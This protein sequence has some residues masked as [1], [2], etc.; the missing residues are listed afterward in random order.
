MRLFLYVA[1]SVFAVLQ[2]EGKTS[3][4]AFPVTNR[5]LKARYSQKVRSMPPMRGVMLPQRDCTEKDFIALR[6]WGVKLCRYQMTRNWGRHNTDRDLAE[7]DS[8]VSGRLDHLEIVLEL[9][10]KHEMKIVVDLHTPPG[11]RRADGVMNMFYEQEYADHFVSLWNTIARRFGNRD[12]IFGFDLINEPCQL[13]NAPFDYWNLQRRAAEEIR[14]I[15]PCTPIIMEAN[16]WD[17]PD[18]YSYMSPIDVYNV[19]YQVHVYCPGEFT[20]QGTSGKFRCLPNEW[21]GS[22]PSGKKWDVH[23]LR[24]KLEPVLSFQKR[25]GAR[26]YVGEFSA[27]AWAKGA[28]N[29]LRDCISLFE[30][31]GWDWSYHAFREWDGWS[32]E[33]EGGS[34]K[35]IRRVGDTSR[36]AALLEGL[37]MRNAK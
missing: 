18:A 28:E 17:S 29:Y 33:H 34:A 15:D 10:K 30:E 16:N 8:W 2:T 20:H 21:P 12:E 35:E 9:A 23:Y 19:I 36:K 22:S 6:D 7:Y 14:A 3:P 26:I 1:A 13:E 31:Y 24:R 4:A 11:G 25:H 32:V 37:Q 5:F 27:I